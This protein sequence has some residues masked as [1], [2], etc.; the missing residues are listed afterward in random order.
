MLDTV[1][2]VAVTDNK[3]MLSQGIKPFISIIIPVYNEA[4][5]IGLILDK[6]LALPFK[7]EIIVVNDGST[8]ET[9][10]ILS[11][12]AE[13][14]EPIR[15]FD[16]KHNIGKGAAV[17]MGLKHVTGDITVIQDADL[18]LDPLDLIKVLKPFE[19][20][21]VHAVFG[22]R[23]HNGN[24]LPRSPSFYANRFLSSFTS[25]LYGQHLWD[26]QTC[27]KAIRTALFKKLNLVSDRFDIDCEITGKLLA[28]KT[29]VH[30]VPVYYNPRKKQDGK[31]LGFWDGI[32]A[33][34]SILKWRI[35][36]LLQQRKDF[37]NLK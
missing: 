10:K 36:S 33:V 31:K 19:S 3:A 12:Y 11:H 8:D 5:T 23:F 14:K 4:S 9:A 26:T 37:S 1:G 22:N 34:I 27:F 13:S 28:R 7:K 17:R 32:E 15:Y 30:W 24:T 18:E 35:K 25:F 16:C 21:D 2:K 29:Q 20:P 6:A